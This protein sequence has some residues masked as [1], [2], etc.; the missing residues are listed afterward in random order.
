MAKLERKWLHHHLNC[1]NGIRWHILTRFNKHRPIN[2]VE[3]LRICSCAEHYS[4]LI[5]II[6][7]FSPNSN[8]CL[9]LSCNAKEW[10]SS[11]KSCSGNE[12]QLL[13]MIH[14]NIKCI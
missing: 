10:S 13:Q 3:R 5:I 8:Q 12:I 4:Q 9:C 1:A 11:I 2:G 6:L 14:N 7:Y